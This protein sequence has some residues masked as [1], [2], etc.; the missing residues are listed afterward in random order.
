MHPPGMHLVSS[1]I[2][3]AHGVLERAVGRVGGR[4]RAEVLVVLAGVFALDG[5]NLGAVGAMAVPLERALGMS[6]V[7]VGLLLT[8]S[9]GMSV[10]AT[11]PFGILVDRTTRTTILA[12]SVLVWAAATVASGAATS[13]GFLLITR[14]VLGAA[15]AS[16]APAVASLV[17]DYFFPEER[18]R[19]WGY[20]LAGELVGTATGVLLSGELANWSWRAG[21]IVLAAPSLLLAWALRRLPEPERGGAG[22]LPPEGGRPLGR[23]V[24]PLQELVRER[25]IAPRPEL[26][27]DRDPRT[28]SF[29]WSI[30]Y[31]LRVPTNRVL[32]IA[33]ALAYA[34]FAGLRA[35]AVDYLHRRYDVSHASSVVLILVL[36]VGAIA[37]VLISGRVADRR[38]EQ[39]HIRARVVIAS[40]GSAISIG[41]LLA[42]L[43]TDTLWLAM[44]LFSIAAGALAGINPPLDSARLDIMVPGLWGRAESV[45]VFLRKA[46]EAGAPFAFG[47]LA[48]YV[49]G[50]E[51]GGQGLGH[52]GA[53]RA[54]VARVLDHH[55]DGDLRGL[56]GREAD[57]PG[58]GQARR[59]FGRARLAGHGHG[60]VDKAMGGRAVAGVGHVPQALAND[61]Q[62]IGRERQGAVDGRRRRFHGRGG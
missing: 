14:A 37:G 38:I 52:G 54:A 4:R 32:I 49:F 17:G 60:H 23:E 8:V 12:G 25:G 33:S 42:G 43:L 29:W 13:F 31:I 50:G 5:A 10:L 57:E 44:L 53:V 16:A 20:V 47:A 59:R 7:D 51:Q 46:G 62:I 15:I 6:T 28:A 11:I 55:G 18:G 36:G 30:R 48:Q 2:V 19:I 34:Y 61:S 24:G 56:V 40:L 27:L 1:S 3:N 21:F 45:R 35:F 58:V 39:G 22:R 9:L 41:F 26:L